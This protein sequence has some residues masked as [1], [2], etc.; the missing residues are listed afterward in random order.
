MDAWRWIFPSVVIFL[1]SQT[2]NANSDVIPGQYILTRDTKT[3]WTD[4]QDRTEPGMRWLLFFGEDNRYALVSTEDA[5]APRMLPPGVLAVQPNYRY[6]ALGITGDPEAAKSWGL[7]NTGQKMPESGVGTPGKDIAA[8]S[9]W[10]VHDGTNP[11]VIAVVDTGIDSAHE[12][13][14]KNMWSNPGEIPGNGIDDDKNGFIDDVHG[15]DFSANKPAVEDDNGHGTFCSGIIAAEAGNGKGSRGV[16]RRA[17]LM[18]VKFLDASGSGSTAHAIAAIKYATDNG[19]Q[20]LN[21]SWGGGKFDQALFDTVKV[22]GERGILFVAAAG[23]D[24]KD[25]DNDP[26]P[27]YPSSFNLP[28]IIS[29]AAYDN[30]DKLARFSNFGKKTVHLGAP[31]VEVFS[32]APKNQYRTGDGTSFAAPFTAGVAALV[33]SFVPGINTMALRD[34]LISS[35]EVI[36]YYEKEKLSSAGRL[37]AYNAVMDIRPPRPKV[38]TTWANHVESAVTPHP[39]P[40]KFTQKWEFRTPGA[41]HVRV[42]FKGFDTE[43]CCDVAVVKDKAGTVVASYAGALGDFWSADVLGD[44]LTVE[45]TAD[46][47]IQAN[48][49]EVTASES[50]QE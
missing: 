40:E 30:K 48:G 16:V 12:E 46:Y 19:A 38:P 35:T 4:L 15:W 23:N 10:A 33:R 5:N 7:E 43:A 21:A 36:G 3:A 29:V 28:N 44:T 11:S 20:I 47:S 2:A 42:K 13:L 1:F 14:A 41:T 6:R 45:F 27:N 31:G 34:R 49:F 18:A 17:K 26:R 25:N 50:S 22:A 37:N 9:A 24:F 8:V 32:T 39:Y